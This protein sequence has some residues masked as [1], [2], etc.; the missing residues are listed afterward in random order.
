MMTLIVV[1]KDCYEKENFWDQKYEVLFVIFTLVL[2]L[3]RIPNEQT[4]RHECYAVY[5]VK[6]QQTF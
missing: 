5:K 4:C 6:L 3:Y 2:L 1:H